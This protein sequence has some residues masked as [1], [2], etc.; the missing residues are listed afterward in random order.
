MRAWIRVRSAGGAVVLAWLAATAHAGV[1]SP[2]W[3]PSTCS[4]VPSRIVLVGS[5]GVIPDTTMGAFDVTMCSFLNPVP[6]AI[7][8]VRQNGSGARL[9]V[10]VYPPSPIV[11][12]GSGVSALGLAADAQGHCRATLTGSVDLSQQVPGVAPTVDIIGNG[13]FFGSVPVVC[14]DLDGSGGVGA[15]DLSAWLTLFGSGQD[16]LVADYD[17]DGKLGAGDLSLWLTVYG[18]G[19]ES[20]SATH[21]CP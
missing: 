6:G 12:C 2:P 9:G 19:R 16:Y 15:G 20:V 7:L 18:S 5:D 10:L 21:L 1:T 3:F 8:G 11:Y 14:Y 4:H 13:S 17:G